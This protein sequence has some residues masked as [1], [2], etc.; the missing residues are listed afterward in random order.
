[1][2][3]WKDNFPTEGRF[4]ETDNGILYH[5]D[6]RN[7]LSKFDN[8]LIDIVVTSPPYN[9]GI[10]YSDWNDTMSVDEYLDFVRQFLVEMKRV[11]KSDGRFAINIPYEVNMKHTGKKT[12]ILLL[13]EYY[14][15]LKELGLGFSSAVDLDE[16]APHRIKFTAWGSW[17]SASAPYIYNPKECVLLGYKDQWEKATNGES[18]ISKEMFKEVVGGIWNYASETR[19]LTLANYSKD[20]PYKAISGLTYKHDIVLDP[21]AGSGTTLV[22]ADSLKRRWIGVEISLEYCN[23]IKRRIESESATLF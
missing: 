19:G 21:F 4:Y 5:G 16:A 17:L 20:I 18:T 3:N 12:R 2:K 14:I 10:K 13:G 11:L 23:V 7:V 8:S 9:V 6:N 22:V 15:L 1:M